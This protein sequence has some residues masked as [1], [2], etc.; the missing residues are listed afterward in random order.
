MHFHLMHY[1][2]FYCSVSHRFAF[3]NASKAPSSIKEL[4]SHKIIPIFLNVTLTHCAP[5]L[6][7][8][9]TISVANLVCSNQH[10]IG[11]EYRMVLEGTR[12][13]RVRD[14]QSPSSTRSS[15]DSASDR[16]P[17]K[18]RDGGRPGVRVVAS[19]KSGHFPDR[20]RLGSRPGH[21]TSSNFLLRHI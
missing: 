4:G 19:R 18:V 11:E 7:S 9:T 10:A 14:F 5:P 8:T 1:Y 13:E 21:H 12:R 16:A 6:T 3:Q 2:I 17:V 20:E 15:S